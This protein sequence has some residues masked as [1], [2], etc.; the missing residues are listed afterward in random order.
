MNVIE[1]PKIYRLIYELIILRKV[2]INKE[3][4]NDIKKYKNIKQY[5]KYKG[6]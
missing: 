3:N 5:I 1:V 6:G 4:I 2:I